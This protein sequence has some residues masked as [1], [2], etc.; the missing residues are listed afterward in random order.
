MSILQE[1]QEIR[2]D[3]G[4]KTYKA[5]ETYLSYHPDLYL[6]DLYYKRAEWEKFEKWYKRQLDEK[7]IKDLNSL[8]IIMNKDENIRAIKAIQE[9]RHYLKIDKI[10]LWGG[11]EIHTEQELYNRVIKIIGEKQTEKIFKEGVK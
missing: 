11:K 9:A 10:I 2:K 3:I 8:K 1:Y 4:E 6:S 5:I 7:L